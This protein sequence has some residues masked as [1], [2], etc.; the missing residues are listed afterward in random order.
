MHTDIWK[1]DPRYEHPHPKKKQSDAIPTIWLWS[2]GCCR[3]NKNKRNLLLNAACHC[4][5]W[6]NEIWKVWLDSLLESWN[7]LPSFG[8]HVCWILL[9]PTPTIRPLPNKL[10]LNISPYLGIQHIDTLEFNTD[11]ERYSD[12]VFLHDAVP[13]H[14]SSPPVDSRALEN[15]L[16][17]NSLVENWN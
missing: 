9:T 2:R 6:G 4:T 12:Q 11:I 7:Y 15:T 17:W 13:H 8:R 5:K 3:K 1:R 16:E 14:F 10:V